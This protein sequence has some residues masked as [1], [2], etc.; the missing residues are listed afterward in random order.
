MP[1]IPPF[2]PILDRLLIKRIEP[3]ATPDGFTV[4]ERYRQHSNLG[5]VIALG[6]GLQLGGVW[7][8]L[9]DFIQVGSIC[10]YGEY[11][12]ECL[13]VDGET[14]WIVRLQDIRGVKE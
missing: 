3:E 6:D 14:Y 12:A 13:E 5:T 1:S 7:R 8:P 2:R 11:T 4:P 9:T 10:M